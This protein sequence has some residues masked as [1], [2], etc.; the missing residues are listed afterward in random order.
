MNPTAAPD[1]PNDSAYR[2]F[3]LMR[4]P[5]DAAWA[6]LAD[7]A[8]CALAVELAFRTGPAWGLGVAALGAFSL[9]VQL[10]FYRFKVAAIASQVRLAAAMLLGG[11]ALAAFGPRPTISLPILFVAGAAKL[12]REL[13]VFLPLR[14]AM[15]RA[16]LRRRVRASTVGIAL[17]G[18]AAG[19]LLATMS[20]G[21][22]PGT[23]LAG[24]SALLAAME[25]WA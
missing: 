9:G 2:P 1:A 7:C 25:I 15:S 23:F 12:L 6:L 8:I 21:Q 10:R 22:A 24:Y 16:G 19:T 4:S 20:Q 13:L 14:L 5:A 3:C 17:A 11:A 18:I